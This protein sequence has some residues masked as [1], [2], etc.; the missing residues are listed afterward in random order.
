MPMEF[1][2]QNIL[3]ISLV[4]VSGASLLWP[5]FARPSG[6]SV[7]PGE[8]TQLINREDAH[9]VDVREAEEFAGGHLPDAINIPAGKLGERVGEL[10]KFK[11][12]PLILCCA[13][14]MRSNKA[15]SELK[16]QGF[17]QLYNL[18][19]GVD[20][21]VGAGYPIKKAGKKK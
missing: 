18:A 19:G 17:D 15:C 12:K 11:S 9:I 10:E 7:S 6:N 3:L 13:S 8:A 1:I 2:N 21:W 5:L 20:A 16:K 4:V 14:G